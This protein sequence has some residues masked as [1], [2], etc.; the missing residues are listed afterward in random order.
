MIRL[1]ITS[2]DGQGLHEK[3]LGSLGPI[4]ARAKGKLKKGFINPT[5]FNQG[6]FRGWG[7]YQDVLPA[8]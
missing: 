5:G 2:D 4:F 1:S 3:A 7:Y 8:S 6:T